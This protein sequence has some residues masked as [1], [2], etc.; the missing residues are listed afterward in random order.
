MPPPPKPDPAVP[1]GNSVFVSKLGA[2]EGIRCRLDKCFLDLLEA[3][4]AAQPGDTVFVYPGDYAIEAHIPLRPG[5]NFQF[6]GVGTVTSPSDV[7][8][9]AGQTGDSD[10]PILARG[11]TFKA[12]A[13]VL[14]FN[15]KSANRR[16]SL[17]FEFDS[18]LSDEPVAIYAG[19]GIVVLNG[20]MIIS[21][22]GTPVQINAGT[23]VIRDCLI[24][25][26]T[27]GNGDAI[28]LNGILDLENCFIHATGTDGIG[29]DGGKLS[30]RGSQILSESAN[31]LTLRASGSV[32]LS[33]CD[34]TGKKS[35][36]VVDDSLIIE[37]DG[38]NYHCTGPGSAVQTSTH[39]NPIINLR[40]GKVSSVN[41]G[42]DISVGAGAITVAG[43]VW[44]RSKGLPTK[45]W[46]PGEGWR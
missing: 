26:D 23:A 32:Q 14:D 25:T 30:V 40:G 36:L 19:E 45:E 3:V 38:C 18:L 41:G 21:P 29:M 35:A 33:N 42:L 24:R 11:W 10:T 37:S 43:T 7:F 17:Y 46:I 27:L 22:N 34:V 2:P 16:A 44:D 5:I 4:A 20:G 1:I 31:G 15:P 13:Q 39:G 6:L 12:A 9:D 28:L 8:S